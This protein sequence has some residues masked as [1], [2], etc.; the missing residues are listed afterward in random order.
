MS[1]IKIVITDILNPKK[2]VYMLF[3]YFVF[4]KSILIIINKLLRKQNPI[5]FISKTSRNQG[6]IYYKL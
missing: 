4:H 1:V 5:S 2:I 3:M 6:N